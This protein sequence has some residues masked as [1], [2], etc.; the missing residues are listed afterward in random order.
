MREPQSRSVAVLLT[1]LVAVGPVSTDLY[2]PSLPSLVG[3]FHTNLARV[4]LTLSVPMT[5]AMALVGTGEFAAYWFLV[6]RHALPR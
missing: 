6:R 1:C 2:L 3:L 5:V 4:Q